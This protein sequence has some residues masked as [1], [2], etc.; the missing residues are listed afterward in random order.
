MGKYQADIIA[1]KR[2]SKTASNPYSYRDRN[3]RQDC[4]W[5]WQHNNRIRMQIVLCNIWRNH[6]CSI[7]DYRDMG[8]RKIETKRQGEQ[9]ADEDGESMARGS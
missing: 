6:N 7:L 2:S 5:D 9:E 8:I 1:T 4:K 3:A